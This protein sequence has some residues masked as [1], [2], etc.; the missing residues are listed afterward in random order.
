MI[1]T[2]PHE[3]AGDDAELSLVLECLPVGVGGGRHEQGLHPALHPLPVHVHRV[4]ISWG[5]HNLKPIHQSVHRHPPILL[6]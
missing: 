5:S 6:R 3:F 1:F 4:K 2:F